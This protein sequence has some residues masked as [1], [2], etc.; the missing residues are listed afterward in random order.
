MAHAKINRILTMTDQLK[1]VY[2]LSND[3]IFSD[4]EQQKPRMVVLKCTES[5]FV[6]NFALSS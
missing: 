2:S 4:L 6:I 5:N 3:A 1:V